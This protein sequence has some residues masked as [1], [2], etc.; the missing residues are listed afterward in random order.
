MFKPACLLIFSTL[1]FLC[2]GKACSTP[3]YDDSQPIF[4]HYFC[5]PPEAPNW[6]QIDKNV[7]LDDAHCVV[8]DLFIQA[9][10]K[11]LI[12]LKSREDAVKLVNAPI[13]GKTE[14]RGRHLLSFSVFNGFRRLAHWGLN[15]AA[16]INAGDKDNATALRMSIGNSLDY[17]ATFALKNKANP[18]R[19][20]GQPGHQD[21]ALS[22]LLK[23]KSPL[24]LFRL[25]IT[26]G[27]KANDP[28]HLNEIAAHLRL[29]AANNA[30]L[31]AEADS[32]I[33]QLTANGFIEEPIVT[34]PAELIE[35]DMGDQLDNAL[36]RAMMAGVLTPDHMD[37]FKVHGKWY[38]HFLAFNGFSSSL[39]YRLRTLPQDEAKIIVEARDDTGNDLLL[40]AIK[41][42]NIDTVRVVLKVSSANI[43]APVPQHPDYYSSGDTPM[44]IARKWQVPKSIIEL[45]KAYGAK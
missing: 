31:Q 10:H 15:N 22:A 33:A 42:L 14:K 41:S 16:D 5:W 8:E 38:E 17:M 18:N 45:L 36:Y 29:M 30:S 39:S 3:F 43:N 11:Q 26:A 21:T 9:Y 1:F 28:L 12:R 2:S 13:S 7:P 4:M 24:S 35:P 37:S 32:L 25:I 44:T 23:W 40:A 20:F 34:A 6:S 19:V 27:G